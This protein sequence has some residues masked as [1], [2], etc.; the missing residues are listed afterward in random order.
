MVRAVDL[1][2]RALYRGVLARLPERIAVRAR[3]VGPAAPPARS[4]RRLPQRGS[5][6]RDHAG[7]RDA[8][9]SADPLVHVLRHA[10]SCGGRWAS[11]SAR[12]PP[13]ASRRGRAPGIR[14]RTSCASRPP[15]GPGLVNCNGFQN[16]GLEAYRPRAGRAAAPRPAHRGRGG[17]VGRGLRRAWSRGSQAFGDLVEINISSPNTKL[18]YGWSDAARTSSKDVFRAVRAATAQADHRQGLAG[19]S[20][21]QRGDHDPGRARRGH[22][23]RQ[24]RQYAPR[25]GAAPLA[26]H[27]RPLGPAP[28]SR[29]RSRTCAGC[30]S[31]SATGIEIIATG[32][33][34]SAR[35]G[36]P[37]ARGGR[38]RVRVSSPD[39]SR[40]AR[41]WRAASS[42]RL[43]R[44][45]VTHSLSTY[46][47]TSTIAKNARSDAVPRGQA[48][49]YDA[50]T[51]HRREALESH[52]AFT[53]SHAP[54]ARQSTHLSRRNEALTGL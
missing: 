8:A 13:R 21:D 47:Q 38:D 20:R 15:E 46:P 22:H 23:H 9:E 10:R 51:V 18:V 2:Y 25:G 16:P 4:P 3:P 50:P 29:P 36:A 26:A 19:F 53:Q 28:C 17:R 42:M 24:L 37:G 35:Q 33:I 41:S 32:G 6:P 49:K 48:R 45:P 1:L 27:R 14:S 11:A 43:S 30:A 39:S 31:D 12:S 52:A 54:R 44:P 7:R 40:A 5:A 34:D